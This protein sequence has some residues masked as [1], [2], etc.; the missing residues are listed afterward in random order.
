[1]NESQSPFLLHNPGIHL[2]QDDSEALPDSRQKKKAP[3]H[4][5]FFPTEIL[6]Q[7]QLRAMTLS[8]NR[9]FLQTFLNFK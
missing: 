3:S 1:M 4:R 8:R 6:G 5:L 2:Q 7:Y 9:D